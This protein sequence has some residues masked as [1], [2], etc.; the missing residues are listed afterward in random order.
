M[1]N[2]IKVPVKLEVLQDSITQLKSVLSSLKPES[3][4]WKEL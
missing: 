2:E 4:A 3:G 1:N